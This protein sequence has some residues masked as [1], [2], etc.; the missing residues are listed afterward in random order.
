MYCLCQKNV[1][2]ANQAM[3]TEVWTMTG[4]WEDSSRRLMLSYLSGNLLSGFSRPTGEKTEHPMLIRYSSVANPGEPQRV[5][6][7]LHFSGLQVFVLVFRVLFTHNPS[8]N[9]PVRA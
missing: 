7:S 9:I 6:L 2:F 4:D 1:G 8:P 3:L 5:D